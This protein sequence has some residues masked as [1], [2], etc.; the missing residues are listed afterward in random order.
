MLE[1]DSHIQVRAGNEFGIARRMMDD[2]YAFRKML[3]ART[4]DVWMPPTDM[5][6]TRDE[7]VIKMSLPGIK[8]TNVRVMFNDE[9]II[10][11]GYRAP[12]HDPGVVAYHQMEIRNGYFERRVVVQKLIN[13]EAATAEYHDGFL[14]VRVPKG[15]TAVA[16]VFTIH[17]NV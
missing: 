6:E 14:W 4:R 2:F 13:P 12:S 9:E 10:V 3:G 7:I 5:Y 15:G 16:R 1:H 11:N 8:T 17:L